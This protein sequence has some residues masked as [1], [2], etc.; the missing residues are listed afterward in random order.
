MQ[1]CEYYHDASNVSYMHRCLTHTASS[2]NILYS[3]SRSLNVC[4]GAKGGQR[5]D[6]KTEHPPHYLPHRQSANTK[7]RSEEGKKR[8]DEKKRSSSSGGA[9]LTTFQ[10]LI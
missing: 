1:N 3:N 5:G 10:E 2:T 4:G 7:H 8:R 6:K 9:V